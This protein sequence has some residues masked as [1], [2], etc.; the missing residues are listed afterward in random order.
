MKLPKGKY[1][2]ADPCYI[3]E[4]EQ[5]HIALHETNYFGYDSNGGIFTESASGKQYAV[6][7]TAFGDGVYQDNKGRDYSVDAGCIACIPVEI[8][9]KPKYDDLVHIEEFEDDFEV[10][11]IQSGG[12]IYFGTIEIMT[13]PPCEEEEEDEGLN[14]FT[15][16]NEEDE[17]ED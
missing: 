7:R 1:Y 14:I 15:Q 2:I 16:F 3:M 11:F 10:G 13:D 17:E 12:V 4:D 9:D 5:Y 6:F 8:V